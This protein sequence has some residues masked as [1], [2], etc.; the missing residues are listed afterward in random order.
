VLGIIPPCEFIPLAEETGLM[1]PLGKAIIVM[2]HNLG[3]SVI[4]EGIE[5]EA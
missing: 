5:E 4:A 2:G 3:F 1:I